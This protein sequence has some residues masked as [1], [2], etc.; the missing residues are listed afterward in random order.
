MNIVIR[1]NSQRKMI[2]HESNNYKH[3]CIQPIII[4]NENFFTFKWYFK[5]HEH[6]NRIE[7]VVLLSFITCGKRLWIEVVRIKHLKC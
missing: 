4:K 5:K 7:E 3:T 1:S 2:A 6:D